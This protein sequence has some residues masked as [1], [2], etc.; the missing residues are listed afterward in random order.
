M[1]HV[2]LL[3]TGER[4]VG[5]GIRAFNS[6]VEELLRSAVRE[7]QIAVYRIDASAL[8]LLDILQ[9]ATCRGVRVLVVLHAMDK[10]PKGVRVKL[11]RLAELPGVRV[12]DFQAENRGFLHTKAIVV[13]RQRAIIGS[14]NLTWGGLI[15]NYEIGILIEG[16]EAWEI[17]RLVDILAEP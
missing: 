13:D 16:P 3:A 8:P 4:I 5:R 9:E 10:Q 15:H 1:K 17:A 11:F 6:V 2:T 7:I 14:A 12:V